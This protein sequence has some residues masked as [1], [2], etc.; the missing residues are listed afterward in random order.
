VALGT[1]RSEG[2]SINLPLASPLQERSED[3]RA[4]P[5]DK[6]RWQ[7]Y[8]SEVQAGRLCLW[9]EA[10]CTKGGHLET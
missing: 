6:R 8:N 3:G 10:E 9:V 7:V 2:S 1:L 5:V 4:V